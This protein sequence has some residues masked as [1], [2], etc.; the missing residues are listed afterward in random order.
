MFSRAPLFGGAADLDLVMRGALR[1]QAG[2]LLGFL[3]RY[4]PAGQGVEAK[5]GYSVG[6]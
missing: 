4:A 5:R 2:W 3:P 1:A 6:A